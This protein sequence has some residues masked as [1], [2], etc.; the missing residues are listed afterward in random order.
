MTAYALTLPQFA[1]VMIHQPK[2]RL[3]KHDERLIT[4]E[5]QYTDAWLAARENE[6]NGT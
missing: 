6:H 5:S 2:Y 1:G 4:T 3:N